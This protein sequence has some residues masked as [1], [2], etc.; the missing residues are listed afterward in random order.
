MVG[1]DTSVLIAVAV[2]ID[3]RGSERI[4]VPYYRV[5]FVDTTYLRLVL[6]RNNSECQHHYT[7]ATVCGGEGVVVGTLCCQH[8]GAELIEVAFTDGRMNR[9]LQAFGRQDVDLQTDHTR[10]VLAVINGVTYDARF[11][12][13]LVTP[14]VRQLVRADRNRVVEEAVHR[15]TQLD[16]TIAAVRRSVTYRIY[17]GGRVGSVFEMNG[18]TFVDGALYR[19]VVFLEYIQMQDDHAVATVNGFDGIAVLTGCTE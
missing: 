12:D 19:V 5:A 18:V 1:V 4:A 14:Y 16:N 2:L 9:F 10:F 7:V 17:T 15:Q 3:A 13:H 11:V 6:N 8:F